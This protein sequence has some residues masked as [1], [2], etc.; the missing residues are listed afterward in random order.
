MVVEVFVE[1]LHE[2]V[3]SNINEN[4]VPLEEDDP[5]IYNSA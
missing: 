4:E 2:A 3:S 5:L 1:E